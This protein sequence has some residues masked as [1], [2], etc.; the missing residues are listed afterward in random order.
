MNKVSE[1]LLALSKAR[2]HTDDIR[3]DF[4]ERIVSQCAKLYNLTGIPVLLVSSR[5]GTA[6][7]EPQT[8]EDYL[9]VKFVELL[10]T[11]FRLQKRNTTHPLIYYIE[12]GYF[13]GICALTQELY[14]I[15]GLIS[16]IPH[17]R[18]EIL[19]LCA[20]VIKPAYLQQL[21][22][23]MIK[24]PLFSLEQL[25]DFICLLTEST[26]GKPLPKE[27]I[28]F[29]DIYLNEIHRP[30]T[31][32]QELFRQRES[33]ELHAP[34]DFETA[35]C[36]AI[37]T[38]NQEELM[39]ILYT[40]IGGRVGK[41]SSDA[42]RQAK[43]TMICMATLASR[44]AIRGGVSEELAFCMSDSFCQCAD[45]AKDILQIQRITFS[46]LTEYCGKVKECKGRQALSNPVTKCM[47]YISDH[48]HESISLDALSVHCNLCSRSLSLRFKAE[49]G[50]GIPEYIHREKIKEAQ[51]L[52]RRDDYSLSEISCF[53]NYPSQSYFTQ[54]FKKYCGMTPQQ[55]RD[56]SYTIP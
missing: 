25:K 28:L 20:T 6:F 3:G 30:D 33:A 22:D 39:K 43:Y 26:Q 36:H 48:L 44:A 31:V 35:V 56:K 34:I 7:M 17:G 50:M 18:Q 53:L 2:I 19:A 15:I 23:R 42:L 16:P 21:C 27:N 41:M 11:D 47:A 55:Y 40:P 29:S 38:G 51:Y 13:L 49:M 10:L 52:L 1:S 5:A 24:M 14:A 8:P 37:E 54:I 4:M 46:M 12:P 9:D 32:S 45:E